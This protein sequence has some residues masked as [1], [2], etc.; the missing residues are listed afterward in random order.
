MPNEDVPV[1][2]LD[3]PPTDDAQQR[4]TRQRELGLANV[5]DARFD[6]LAR[7][8][9]ERTGALA[10]MVNL[11]GD[12]RQ[13]F[14][15]LAVKEGLGPSDPALLGDPG[16]EMDLDHGFCPHVVTRRKALVLDDVFAYPRF[17]GNP[18]VDELGVR[19]YLGAPIID[20]DGTVLGTV[21]AVDPSPRSGA[22]YEGWGH[23]GLE[24]IK[25][26]AGEVVA[27]IRAR[28]LVD[29]ATNAAP[30]SVMI[31]S[32]PGQAVLYANGAHEQLFGA[33]RQLGDPAA[34]TF[35]DLT[36]VGVT[37]AL[38][39]VQRT[40]E[41]CVTAPV[42]LAENGRGVL[43]AAVPARVPGHPRAVLTLGMVETEAAHCAQVAADLAVSLAK[44]CD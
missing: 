34:T 17:A 40:G 21:C 26:V 27:E 2:L 39:Q 14:A 25:Q 32:D 43:F 15:G 11:V 3:G 20:A 22:E 37:A 8:I 23:R 13:Y 28:Q 1:R 10:A 6:E 29:A 12:Q 30:G 9:V 33:A 31:T 7:K 42:R 35:P 4:V 18:V 44:L 24:V 16:R 19:S 38:D 41:P 36:A 5:P